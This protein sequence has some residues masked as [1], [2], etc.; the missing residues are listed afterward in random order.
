[1]KLK[2][3]CEEH[4]LH[5]HPGHCETP[6]FVGHTGFSTQIDYVLTYCQSVISRISIEGKSPLDMSSHVSVFA[7]LNFLKSSINICDAKTKAQTVRKVNWEKVNSQLHHSE[8]EKQLLKRNESQDALSILISVLKTAGVNS[9]PNRLIK[10]KGPKFKLSPA[11]KKLESECK[12]TFYLWKQAGSPSPK[13]PLS[14]QRKVAKSEMRKQI[15]R[16]FACTRDAF[17]AELLDNPSDKF[18]N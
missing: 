10:V 5:K 13:H 7:Q 4:S 6:T 18:F 2:D 11:V 8:L 9:V 15:R 3:F 16:E 1:M 14:I 12:R 17:Y